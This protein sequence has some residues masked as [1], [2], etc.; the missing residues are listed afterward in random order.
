MTAD[1]STGGDATYDLTPATVRLPLRARAWLCVR[2]MLAHPCGGASKVA[3]AAAVGVQ[4]ASGESNH[5]NQS[6][7]YFDETF[8]KEA[9]QRAHAHKKCLLH[10]SHPFKT[11]WDLALAVL[12]IYSIIVVPLR[13]GFEEDASSSSVICNGRRT[14][15]LT[16]CEHSPHDGSSERSTPPAMPICARLPLTRTCTVLRTRPHRDCGLAAARLPALTPAPGC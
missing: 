5:S 6:E 11:G 10:P 12:V 4:R 9:K 7:G 14:P 16:R 2:H 3:P 1:S 13:I 15:T 8:D